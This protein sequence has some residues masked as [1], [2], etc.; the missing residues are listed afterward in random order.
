MC[1]AEPAAIAPALLLDDGIVGARRAP[2]IGQS[3]SGPVFGA[4]SACLQWPGG[5]QSPNFAL[6]LSALAWDQP[7][8]FSP[9]AFQPPAQG[10][11]PGARI[12]VPSTVRTS[13]S[14]APTC[15]SPVIVT[16]VPTNFASGLFAP[17]N[18]G[19]PAPSS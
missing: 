11:L 16:V 18:H 7:G 3:P 12:A 4:V 9:T 19:G 6:N 15:V 2:G 8:C 14:V 10:G 5:Q 1:I 13:T 17:Q